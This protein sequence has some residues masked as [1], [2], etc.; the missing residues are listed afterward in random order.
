MSFLSHKF[1]SVLTLNLFFALI[2]VSFDIAADPI[3][4][5]DTVKLEYSLALTNGTPISSSEGKKPLTIVIGSGEPFPKVNQELIGMNVNDEKEITLLPQHAFGPVQPGMFKTV[6]AKSVPEH[7]RKVGA[8][9]VAEGKNGKELP[10]IVQEVKGDKIVL[11][12]NH[13]LAGRALK[14]KAR[15]VGIEQ[16]K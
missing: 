15:V 6:D 7:L 16:A 3:K 8:Q 12:F 4:T 11:N 2:L 9:L 1:L 13:P 10:V 5:G 14:F